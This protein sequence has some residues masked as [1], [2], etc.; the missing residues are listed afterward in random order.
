MEGVHSDIMLPSR[1]SY[2][3]IGERDTKKCI[4]IWQSS[5]SQLYTLEQL[6]KLWSCN[7]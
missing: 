4:E 7:Q 2:M 5:C 1:Y 3:E 6:R